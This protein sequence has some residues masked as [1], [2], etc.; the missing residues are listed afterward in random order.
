MKNWNEMDLSTWTIAD[1]R[2]EGCSI[3]LFNPNE[4]ETAPPT[5]VEDRLV[6]LGW[7]VIQDLK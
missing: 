3:V 7:E 5:K 1:L 4:L 6:E 2:N